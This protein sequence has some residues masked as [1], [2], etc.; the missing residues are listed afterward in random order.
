MDESKWSVRSNVVRS[1]S[2]LLRSSIVD[3][4][5]I[6]A[7]T[8]SI[9]KGTT[10]HTSYAMALSVYY[11][12]YAML[13][14]LLNNKVS[15]DKSLIS[16]CTCLREFQPPLRMLTPPSLDWNFSSLHTYQHSMSHKHSGGQQIVNKQL[17]LVKWYFDS[18]RFK[19]VTWE[20]NWYL[21]WL[22]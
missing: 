22:K 18:M 3:P 13:T 16:T 4:P 9:S 20:W 10:P 6:L 1:L 8:S 19:H 14:N 17:K 11:T 5:W 21:W 7:I 12:L 15:L 2:A